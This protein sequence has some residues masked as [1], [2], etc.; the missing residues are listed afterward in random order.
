VFQ[1][2][3]AAIP[4]DVLAAYTPGKYCDVHI[5]PVDIANIARRRRKERTQ[6]DDADD[7]SVAIQLDEWEN[8]GI[9]VL[10]TYV[11][12]ENGTLAFVIAFFTPQQLEL[13][14]RFGH[15]VMQVD[16]THKTTGHSYQL[17]SLVVRD[18]ASNQTLL[19][20]SM[21]SNSQKSAVVEA[22]LTWLR[23]EGGWV[24]PEKFNTDQ[25][26]AQIKAL[27]KVFP[28]SKIQLCIVHMKRNWMQQ[29]G[30]CKFKQIEPFLN[31]AVHA[32]DVA[33]FDVAWIYLVAAAMLIAD[34][35]FLDYIDKH[36]LASC[37]KFYCDLVLSA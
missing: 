23:D 15:K 26:K 21:I 29:L 22:W 27:K 16:A 33:A 11:L 3:A 24:G 10:R 7:R 20:A 4:D 37:G 2:E 19:V 34:E 14:R 17:Y 12:L 35:D 32:R 28:A 1:D 30:A 25:D 8:E 9:S 13:A 36:W 5:T 31:A 18:P 6:R